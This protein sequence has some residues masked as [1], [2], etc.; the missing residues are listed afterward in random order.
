METPKDSQNSNIEDSQIGIERWRWPLSDEE[1][2]M[3]QEYLSQIESGQEKLQVYQQIRE[4]N[5][6]PP[7]IDADQWESQWHEDLRQ[8]GILTNPPIE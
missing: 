1:W 6:I 5:Q 4:T 3:L 8:A 2:Q 7:S